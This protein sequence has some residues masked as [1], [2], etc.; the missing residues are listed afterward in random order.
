MLSEAERASAVSQF[1]ELIRFKTVSGDGPFNGA[2]SA[3]GDWLL[4][5][6]Q[7]LGLEAEIIPESKP[8]KPIIVGRWQGLRPELPAVLLNSHY[9]VVPAVDSEWSVPAFDGLQ[10]EGKI[11][12]RG[13]QDM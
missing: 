3:C 12:G 10:R 1:I 13:T 9:D 4:R 11:Y 8:N 2:Y 5:K 7:E 6:L